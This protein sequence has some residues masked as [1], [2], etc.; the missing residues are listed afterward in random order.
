MHN[1]IYVIKK[2]NN[3][4]LIKKFNLYKISAIPTAFLLSIKLHLY[5]KSI[6]KGLF[7]LV[8]CAYK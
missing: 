6:S 4:S 1:T 7:S 2:A 3:I 5:P 8:V